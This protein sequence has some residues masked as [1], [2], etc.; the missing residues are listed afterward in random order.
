M[1]KI[2][3]N[4][5]SS[6]RVISLSSLE[7]SHIRRSVSGR[8]HMTSQGSITGISLAFKRTS[9]ILLALLVTVFSPVSTYVYAEGTAETPP[10]ADTTTAEPVAVTETPPPTTTEAPAPIPTEPAPASSS[11]TPP[12]PVAQEQPAAQVPAPAPANVQG[13][14][15]P[16]GPERKSY[17]YNPETKLYEN[18]KYT[19]DPVT[20]KTAPKITPKYSYN[21]VTG[22]WDTTEWRYD[23][24]SGKYVPN[25]VSVAANPL[26]DSSSVP[27]NLPSDSSSDHT[28]DLFYNA[29]ISN[30]FS[31]QATTGN[32][33][34]IGNTLGG[35]ALSGDALA[36][37]NIFNLL[38]SSA[39]FLGG[40]EVATFSSDIY[41]DVYGDLYIDPAVLATLQ[42]ASTANEAKIDINVA[43]SGQINN[44]IALDAQSGDANVQKNTTAGNATSG[45]ATAILN[46]I[47][48]INSAISTGGSFMGMLNI[49]GNLNGD[50]LL[51]ENILQTLLAANG[52]TNAIDTDITANLSDSQSI[53]N[54]VDATAASGA[55]SVTHNTTAGAAT[56]GD[57]S[58]NITLLNLTG[59]QVVGANSLLVFVNVLGTWVGVIMDAPTGSTSA[60]LGSGITENTQS[61][62]AGIDS[63]TDS[64]INNNVNVNAASGDATV[65][66]NTTAGN[67]TTGDAKAAVNI[68]NIT[69]SSF[70]F[71]DWFGV[72]FINVFGTWNGS[73]G[74]DTA[75]GEPP[76]QTPTGQSAGASTAQAAQPKVF[77]FVPKGQGT[78]L[79]SVDM[80]S[81][82]SQAAVQEAVKAA[83]KKI[84][85]ERADDQPIETEQVRESPKTVQG[86][87]Y[88]LPIVGFALGGSMLGGERLV[89]RRQRRNNK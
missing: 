50:I 48:L 7:H 35:S 23:A 63:D 15:Q 40:G 53:N 83:T 29:S 2:D 49:Y 42:P 56:T 58:T 78:T 74:V 45:S 80:N 47:N 85:A 20:G 10:P 46:L 81:Q 24:P 38:Q 37:A 59:R 41:G 70:N 9:L 55:A 79:A 44:D 84:E 61:L 75:A 86:P 39:S 71:A 26:T 19:W 87:D 18:D 73:F 5:S 31:S 34:V 77:R 54:N 32:A 1:P 33:S 43:G 76:Q 6:T 30:A 3:V 64:Q 89:N 52:S 27:L 65:A 13:P 11:S 4:N 62:D 16:P 12:A 72:L 66:S 82:E 22:M 68:L 17:V 25:I 28:F 69:N 36:L 67:A 57:A 88:L 8:S 60:A 21:T 14:T 51:P